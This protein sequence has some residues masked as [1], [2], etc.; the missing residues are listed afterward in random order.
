MNALVPIIAGLSFY[1]FIELMAA[2]E[3]FQDP[4]RGFMRGRQSAPDGISFH[5][6]LIALEAQDNHAA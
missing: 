5:S 6:P 1:A 2:V 4:Q 3:G